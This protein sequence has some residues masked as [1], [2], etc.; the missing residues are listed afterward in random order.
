VSSDKV[1]LVRHFDLVQRVRA[2]PPSEMLAMLGRWG[3][4]I[5]E[6]APLRPGSQGP[7]PWV[8]AGLARESLAYGDERRTSKWRPGYL[9][10]LHDDFMNLD[11]PFFADSSDMESFLGSPGID[12]G[13]IGA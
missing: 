13:S 6:G 10:R 7:W 8:I 11:D 2:H 1:P 9:P 5:S 3:A 12:V 4:T